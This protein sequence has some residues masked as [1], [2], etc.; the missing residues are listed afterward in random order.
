MSYPA[1]SSVSSAAVIGAA[2][3]FLQ[4]GIQEA[5]GGVA[6]FYRTD[7]GRNA[8]LSTEITGYALSALVFFAQRTGDEQYLDSARRAADFLLQQ[9][10][11][12]SGFFPFEISSDPL[13]YF[14]DSG[15][16]IRGLLALWGKTGDDSL[17][18][19]AVRAGRALQRFLG[20]GFPIPPVLRFRDLTPLPLDP[21]R[22]SR[23]PGCYQLKAALA[24]RQL[25]DITGDGDFLSS[26][27][28]MLEHALATHEPF[29]PGDSNPIHVVDRLHAYCYFLEALLHR[30]DEPAFAA[31]IAGGLQR[32]QALA[33]EL[34]SVAVR[35]DVIA[36]RLRVQLLSGLAIDAD[37]C[38]AD[39]EK[40]RSFQATDPPSHAGGFWFGTRHGRLLP[41]INPVS[42]IF[43][44]Q[45]LTLW[46]DYN[47]SDPPLD[48]CI[49]I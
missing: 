5:S 44:I 28:C 14:F 6:R 49:L 31:M 47:Q 13:I 42:T 35:S 43:A 48:P 25:F 23:T 30:R 8:P 18:E 26:F 17:L 41:F 27:E 19:A 11:E 7:V 34:A 15:I 38:A 4:S 39:A 20:F 36:Q 40:L 12:H 2:R 3:W 46:E 21:T 24:W 9:E 37:R 16:I 29:L 33:D 10:I 32:V 1:V 22:W 45:A